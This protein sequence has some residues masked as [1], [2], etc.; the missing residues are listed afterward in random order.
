M[1]ILLI[2]NGT[3]YLP[4]LKNLLFGHTVEVAKYFELDSLDLKDFDIFVLSGGHDIPLIG[5][6]RQFQKEIDLV[7]NSQKPIF[8]I[9][10]GFELIAHVFSGRLERM[11]AKEHGM[12]DI[13]ATEPGELLFDTASFQVFESHC[14]VVKEPTDEMTVLAR[15]KDGIEAFKHKTRPIYAVQFHPEMFGERSYGNEIF[16]N[17]LRI[18]VRS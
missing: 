2:D 13:Q 11:E 10:F 12:V 9:C 5:N 7:K 15:S 16:Q 8:G 17:F 4:Q 14:W 6:E 18:I 1:N 3:S